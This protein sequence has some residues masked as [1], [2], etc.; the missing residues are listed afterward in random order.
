LHL[1]PPLV[2]V[3]AKSIVDQQTDKNKEMEERKANLL[4]PE[5]PPTAGDLKSANQRTT[6]TGVGGGV[7]ADVS[8]GAGG[9]SLRGPA[10][11][12]SSARII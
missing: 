9:S 5:Q 2:C 8:S 11:A 4:L 6:G 3:T 7:T 12:E 1:K 10:S